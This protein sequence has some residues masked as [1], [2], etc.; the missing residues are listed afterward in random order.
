MSPCDPVRHLVKLYKSG[1]FIKACHHIF[2]NEIIE[3]GLRGLQK[4]RKERVMSH[5]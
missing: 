2:F 3:Y 5:C 4:K 1:A